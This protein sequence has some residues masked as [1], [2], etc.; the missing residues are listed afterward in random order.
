MIR[1]S[2]GTRPGDRAVGGGECFPRLYSPLYSVLCLSVFQ[3]HNDYFDTM[4]IL[5]TRLQTLDQR[6]HH[7][8]AYLAIN[9]LWNFSILPTYSS[10][11]ER[12]MDQPSQPGSLK[13]TYL[14]TAPSRAHDTFR[15]LAR[16]R[17]QRRRKYPLHLPAPHQQTR[18]RALQQ[19]RDSPSISS[20]YITS[21]GLPNSLALLIAFSGISICGNRYMAP[22]AG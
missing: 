5:Q 11:P 8:Y 17:I 6:I 16:T 18:F 19:T 2:A 15:P 13:R 7:A 10:T 12:S 20:A 21:A 1:H 4:D 3:F 22:S 14:D 9:S